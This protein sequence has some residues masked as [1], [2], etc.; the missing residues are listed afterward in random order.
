MV[1]KFEKH[2]NA[3]ERDPI[4]GKPIGP[5]AGAY[6]SRSGPGTENDNL[7]DAR[8]SAYFVGGRGVRKTKRNAASCLPRT[9]SLRCPEPVL[10]NN[11]SI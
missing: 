9:F 7:P 1:S 3:S 5:L 11:F 2:L 4:T 10:A 6:K 8:R